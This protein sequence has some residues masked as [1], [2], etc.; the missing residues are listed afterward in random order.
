[1]KRLLCSL[2]L[3]C[4][5][6]AGILQPVAAFG[7]GETLQSV[8]EPTQE[9][10]EAPDTRETE[11]A[12]ETAS[13]EET[14]GETPTPAEQPAEEPSEKPSADRR[15]PT[16]YK[17]SA[18]GI[19]FINEMM[20]GSYGGT[21]QLSGAESAVNSF[22][23]TNAL[24]LSQQ[25]FDALTD[26]C[27]AYGNIL[28]SGYSWW[29]PLTA[30][31]AT[32]AQIASAFCAWVKGGDGLLSQERLNRRLREVKL[33]LYGSY[34]GV[35]DAF[36][37]YVAFNGNGGTLSD[38]TVI[39]YALAET[40]GNLPAATRS[41]KYFAGWYTAASGGTHLCNTDLV[42]Q[43]YTVY[44]QWSDTEVKDPNGGSGDPKPV[45]PT[46]LDPPTLRM[47]EEG[48]QFIKDNEG[49][50]KYAVWD[51]AQ[52]SIGYGSRCEKDEFPDGIT[53]EEADYRLR[54]M[55]AEFEKTLDA[56]EKKI[57]RTLTQQQYDA[58]LSFT[59]NVGSG[60][61]SN[62]S[63]NINKLVTT[64]A[65]TEM[66]FVNTIGSWI[67][68]GGET[69]AGLV[70]RRMDE[71]NMY[72]NGQYVKGSRVYL[73]IAYHPAEG[74]CTTKYYYYKTGVRLG[75]LPTPTRSG[76]RF[77]GWYD[78]LVG[79]TRYTAD[80]LAPAYGDITVYAHWQQTDEPD[81]T[82]PTDSTAPTE[83]TEPTEP[84]NPT[85]PID[86][87]PIEPTFTDVSPDAWYYDSVMRAVRAGLFGGVS[88]TEF[89]PE[90]PMTRGMLV[91]V[92]WRYAGEPKA[93]KAAPFTDV[94]AGE[95]YSSAVAWAYERGIVNGISA[96]TF[97]VNDN[98]TREQLTAM[99]CR[100]A[101]SAGFDVTASAGLNGFTDHAAV[102]DYALYAMRW[103]VASGIVNGDGGKLL[104][105][106]N[107]TRAQC[108]KM[109]IVFT[110]K[111]PK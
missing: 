44:A 42:T 67:N 17:T 56:F 87:E 101:A 6:T 27:M 86:P 12:A 88:N 68:A 100:Y 20:G 34:S 63:Y 37:R 62:S 108:A 109:M 98:V 84:T 80:T 11:T 48:V 45:D 74:N 107:A 104:P 106:G 3:I 111:Y 14:E 89:A 73:R 75:T 83:P 110:E 64:G 2:L 49:F 7:E 35:C 58:L 105:A 102:S 82:E 33:Y 81:P 32:D 31:G 41:G 1:M 47:S 9:P 69:L 29:K 38:N 46:P 54:V 10:T 77:L 23:T 57:G 4:G 53:E 39:C 36:F 103:A 72:L 61:M 52:W 91:T 8:S 30:S 24:E 79:G 90:E 95:W 94:A 40:Y 25:Q 70:R 19:A 15:S 76:Y 26:I 78:K 51:Y 65:Y 92:L 71:A 22:I 99:L 43:N 5:L 28:G 18:E 66:E 13:A 16:T 97:G 59:Y 96:T 93:S 50:V 21:Y 85:E 60:W 55:L